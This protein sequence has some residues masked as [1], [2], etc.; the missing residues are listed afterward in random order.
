MPDHLSNL[1]L[2]DVNRAALFAK[3]DAG[4][5]RRQL[6]QDRFD[7]FNQRLDRKLND[8]TAFDDLAKRHLEPLQVRKKVDLVVTAG[9]Q[10][11]AKLATGKTTASFTHI[12][13]GIGTNAESAGDMALQAEVRRIAVTDR[14]DSGTSMKFSGFFDSTTATGAY[15]EFGLFDAAASGNMLSRSVFSPAINHT[16]NASVFTLTQVISQSAS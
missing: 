10:R 3:S 14:F 4:Y 11:L 13:C 2:L 8:Q 12:A 9:L 5:V 1:N 7:S 15:T 6:Y 16:Q